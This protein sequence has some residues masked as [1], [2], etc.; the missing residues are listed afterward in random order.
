MLLLTLFCLNAFRCVVGRGFVPAPA[1]RSVLLLPMLPVL[2]LLL[3]F[4]GVVVVVS[5]SL[6][7]TLGV[8]GVVAHIVLALV[9]VVAIRE[10]T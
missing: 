2:L 9:L 7:R 5:S 10:L 6:L 3:P 8:V 1:P 4:S